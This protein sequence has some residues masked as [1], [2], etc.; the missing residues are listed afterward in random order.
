MLSTRRLACALFIGLGL[1]S[2]ASAFADGGPFGSAPVLSGSVARPAPT[3]LPPVPPLAL[4]A[5]PAAAKKKTGWTAA[6]VQGPVLW[7]SADPRGLPPLPTTPNSLPLAERPLQTAS[8]AVST[9]SSLTL[10]MVVI[11]PMGR[12]ALFGE[13]WARPKDLV[14][15]QTT[16][17]IAG[18][19][20]GRVVLDS[21][22]QVRV[23]YAV[24]TSSSSKTHKVKAA[25]SDACL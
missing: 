3:G 1:A 14:P 23:G 20:S 10:S 11:S 4:P 17:R 25:G 24:P 22:I 2:P 9:P 5:M 8:S 13:E 7:P 16:V 21:G 12:K 15:G 18:I 6:A 19:C